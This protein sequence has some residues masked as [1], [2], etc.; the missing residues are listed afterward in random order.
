MIDWVKS[1]GMQLALTEAEASG[2]R[3]RHLCSALVPA[4]H[5]SGPWWAVVVF[6]RGP[7]PDEPRRE[8]R[9]RLLEHAPEDAGGVGHRGIVYA[10]LAAGARAAGQGS[11]QQAEQQHPDH[12]PP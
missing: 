11:H 1:I 6:M 3:K 12:G 2:K 10:H 9:P 7:L 8:R 4:A 5:P